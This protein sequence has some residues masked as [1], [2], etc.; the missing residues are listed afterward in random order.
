MCAG[1]SARQTPAKI[2]S[3]EGRSRVVGF[4]IHTILQHSCPPPHLKTKKTRM[5]KHLV[6]YAQHWEDTNP[7]A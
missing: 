5:T 3:A 6:V 4:H 2:L 7:A 1:C